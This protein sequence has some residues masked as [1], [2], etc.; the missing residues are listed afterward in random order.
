MA[1]SLVSSPSSFFGS[2]LIKPSLSSRHGGST[3]GG[4]SVQFL[5]YR[6]NNKLFSSS[7]TVRFSWN[8]I[9]PFHGLDSSVDIGAIL[10]RAESLLYTIADA[11]VVGADSGAGGAA[12]TDSAVQKSGGWFGFI[13][14]GMEL[15]L[16]VNLKQLIPICVCKFK[17]LIPELSRSFKFLFGISDFEGWTFGNSCAVRLWICDHLAYD[18]RQSS[19]LPFDKATGEQSLQ[20]LGAFWHVECEFW[21]HFAR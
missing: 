20:P 5:P 7:T 16:K 10:T 13:S 8:E 14:D 4:G 17:Q 2:P 21:E 19:H 1:R 11:A 9:P 6:S 15:V 18:Y 3:G 12:S